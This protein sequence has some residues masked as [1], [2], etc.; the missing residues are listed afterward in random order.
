MT[1]W[2]KIEEEDSRKRA[3]D[4]DGQDQDTLETTTGQ[5]GG[6]REENNECD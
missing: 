5:W 3:V 1:S 4:R 2:H 6:S